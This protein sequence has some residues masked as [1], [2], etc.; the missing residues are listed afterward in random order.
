MFGLK[1]H[2]FSC[3]YCG[4]SISMELERYY[5]EQEYIEDCQ[6]CCN[7]ILVRYKFSEDQLTEFEA[8]SIEQ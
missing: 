3:P 2:I 6:V 5:P 1:E 7:P 4:S 8:G